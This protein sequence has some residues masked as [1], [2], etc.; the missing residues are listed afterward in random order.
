MHNNKKYCSFIIAKY[1]TTCCKPACPISVNTKPLKSQVPKLDNNIIIKQNKRIIKLSET[2][3]SATSAT[4]SL[5]NWSKANKNKQRY[6][7][8]LPI[9]KLV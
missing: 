3:N 7:S 1:F 2:R 4:S 6:S 5:T 9:I 8:L